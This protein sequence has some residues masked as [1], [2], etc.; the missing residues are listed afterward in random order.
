MGLEA[1]GGRQRLL[2]V[3]GDDAALDPALAVEQDL[4]APLDDR[5]VVDDQD[6]Q[7]RLLGPLVR[8]RL[9]RRSSRRR[10]RAAPGAPATPRPRGRTRASR[11]AASTHRRRG[12]GRGPTPAADAAADCRRFGP[13]ARRRPSLA[14][15]RDPDLGRLGVLLGVSKRLAE[16]RDGERLEPLRHLGAR[17]PP[18]ADRDRLVLA[19]EPLELGPQGGPR[20][21]RR[22]ARASGRARLG[23][24]PA[25]PRPR[26]PP[27][28]RR[29]R[30]ARRPEPSTIETPKSR[31]MTLSWTSRASSTRSSRS[32]S[33]S[34]WATAWRTVVA[35]AAVRPSAR[36]VRRSSSSSSS[37]APLRSA[38]ITPSQRPAAA[39]G[40]QEMP[41]TAGDVGVAVGH[42]AG[43]RVDD[44]HA[45]SASARWAIGVSSSPP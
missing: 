26:P 25:P 16:H 3:G 14:G 31:C 32:A 24:R 45:S 11:P 8:R 1:L 28:R 15:D 23:A 13:R 5:V 9:R 10:S 29:R 27:A 39:T 37:G 33:R 12:A 43:E 35:S 41:P 30:S 42:C 18:D 44:D 40:V 17:L 6:A 7:R 36:I 21:A 20:A 22:S 19:P 2:G 4:E 34:C 38:K